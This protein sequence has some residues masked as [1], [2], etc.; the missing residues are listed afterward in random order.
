MPNYSLN[1]DGFYR[2]LK[3]RFNQIDIPYFHK[4]LVNVSEKGKFVKAKVMC[5]NK[6]CTIHKEVEQYLLLTKDWTPG[7]HNM[8]FIAVNNLTID[9]A[10]TIP[11]PSDFA[12]LYDENGNSIVV[13]D[14]SKTAQPTLQEIYTVVEEA[15]EYPE[16]NKY[17]RTKLNQLAYLPNQCSQDTLK[18]CKVFLKFVVNTNGKISDPQIT[19]GCPTCLAADQLAL[20]L[21]ISDTTTWK[22]GKFGGKHVRTYVNTLITFKP[23]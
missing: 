18:P 23:K 20:K 13:N 5:G 22:P 2:K 21:L 11:Q 8:K 9:L 6:K 7:I 17:F 10:D 3:A 1:D 14:K 19:K 15:P 12:V 16:G 4:A